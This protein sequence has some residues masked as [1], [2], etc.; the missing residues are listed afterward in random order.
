[1]SLSVARV[2]TFSGGRRNIGVAASICAHREVLTLSTPL[3]TIVLDPPSVPLWLSVVVPALNEA[4]AIV[5]TLEPF[6]E[7]RNRGVE[8]VLVDGHSDDDTIALA[9]PLCDRI[10]T[11]TTPGR[12]IQM[13]TGACNS[14]GRLL[15]FLH[16]D[17]GLSSSDIDA[18]HSLEA[19][20]ESLWGRFDVQLQ[21]ARGLLCLVE[22]MINWRSR[23]SG[24]ATGDQ[25]MF[26]TRDW[27]GQVGGFEMIP[28]ME[29]IALSRVLR[30][31]GAP[32]FLPGPARTSARR[33]YRHG[34]IRTI[35]LMW[36]LRAAFALGV[37]PI[38]LKRFYANA[39]DS[40]AQVKR[41]SR[42]EGPTR[43][44]TA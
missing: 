38:A 29:D 35:V 14:T 1:M 39:A 17:T 32:R 19:S 36:C 22:R 21:G 15:L 6:Q 7:W 41:S 18:L 30:R 40:G 13:H 31:L 27:Y 44:P 34:V 23:L 4:G 43:G 5:A 26:V 8:I 37:N 9:Q 11:A 20:G 24:I 25:G 33:W 28:L 12:A 16:A 2:V 10:L 3:T 42:D